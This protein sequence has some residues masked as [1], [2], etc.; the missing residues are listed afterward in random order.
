MTMARRQQASPALAGAEESAEEAGSV[1]E[2]WARKKADK[3]AAAAAGRTTGNPAA[4]VGGSSIAPRSL[5]DP[6]SKWGSCH[7]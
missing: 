7:F 2:I 6:D 5:P 3:V 4:Y 1:G